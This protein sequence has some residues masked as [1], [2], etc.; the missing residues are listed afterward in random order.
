MAGIEIRSGAVEQARPL[1]L[2]TLQDEPT[3]WG[4]AML[5]ML[6]RQVGNLDEALA[7]AQRALDQPSVKV[8][9]AGSAHL[10]DAVEA[11]LL[12]HEVSRERNA[13]GESAAALEAAAGLARDVLQD[14]ITPAARARAERLLAR[15]LDGLGRRKE[16]AEALERA[17][18][19]AASDGPSIGP[20]MLGVVSRA[21]AVGDVSQARA[22]LQR[23]LDAEVDQEDLV[24]GAL[25]LMFLE[26]ELGASTDG[27]VDRVLGRAVLDEGWTGALA[28][29]ARGRVDDAA[30]RAAAR[31]Y[32]QRIEAEFYLAMKGRL[33]GRPNAAADLQKVASNP[34][35]DLMEV[36]L[37]RD[38]MARA[39]VAPPAK[40]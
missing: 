25:W 39:P 22:A 8:R 15:A 3:V 35:I 2:A 23:G 30:L 36:H 40:P 19:A 26:Q 9:V 17:Q 13:T 24:Y 37:A 10:L 38:I 12:V 18:L 32:S 7:H 21:L 34:L 20:T 16:A 11:H 1:L 27:K 31:S 14:R 29:W 5:G 4:Y 33:V 6:E 28:R